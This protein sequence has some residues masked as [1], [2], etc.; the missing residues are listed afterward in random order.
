MTGALCP[1]LTGFR[2]DNYADVNCVNRTFTYHQ[3][4]IEPPRYEQSF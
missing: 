4:S 1:M 3:T 2:E